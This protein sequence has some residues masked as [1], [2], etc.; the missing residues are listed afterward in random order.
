MRIYKCERIYKEPRQKQRHLK[1]ILMNFSF[2]EKQGH[3]KTKPFCKKK[4]KKRVVRISRR[5]L[6]D[7]VS[8]WRLQVMQQYLCP[9]DTQEL[10][11]L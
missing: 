2:L 3:A 1:K 9:K 10:L 7:C 6:N 8:R 11:S 4:K 5:D